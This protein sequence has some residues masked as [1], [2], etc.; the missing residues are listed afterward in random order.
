V[1]FARQEVVVEVRMQAEMFALYTWS[2]K[3]TVGC[4]LFLT[5]RLGN[6]FMDL[7]MYGMLLWP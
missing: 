5:S 4:R 3:A 6:W 2:H 7:L 1:D